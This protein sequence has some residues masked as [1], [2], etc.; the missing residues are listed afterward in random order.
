M[1]EKID[2]I[3]DTKLKASAHIAKAAF[4]SAGLL[5]PESRVTCLPQPGDGDCLF[6]ALAAGLGGDV[7]GY[8]LKKE[9]MSFA[10]NN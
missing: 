5:V 8:D 4:S 10:T 1:D 2:F 7:S 6:H 9:L 3:V